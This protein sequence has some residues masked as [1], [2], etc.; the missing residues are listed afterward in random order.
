MAPVGRRGHCVL[1]TLC[2]QKLRI[3]GIVRNISMQ[4]ALDMFCILK[5]CNDTWGS[6]HACPLEVLFPSGTT[7]LMTV[8]SPHSRLVHAYHRSAGDNTEICRGAMDGIAE[9]CHVETLPCW[10]QLSHCESVLLVSVSAPCLHACKRRHVALAT[11]T[12]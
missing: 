4:Y 1:I 10:I 7:A 12:P 8:R 2:F 5:V 6:S 3:L 11:S 9:H